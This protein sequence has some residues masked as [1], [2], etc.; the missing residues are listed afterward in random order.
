MHGSGD[1]GVNRTTPCTQEAFI[2]VGETDNI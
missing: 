1:A 2:L